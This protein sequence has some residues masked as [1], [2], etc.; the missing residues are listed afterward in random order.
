M[1]TKE[2]ALEKAKKM[3]YGWNTGKVELVPLKDVNKLIR[4]IYSIKP[5]TFK[6]LHKGMWVWID[7]LETIAL[8]I[9]FIQGYIIEIAYIEFDVFTRSYEPV[10]EIFH[11]ADNTLYPITKTM[12]YQ[13]MRSKT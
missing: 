4:E 5:Y 11:F 1:L 8:I 9:G 12:E 6:D 7:E 3:S 13:E 2:E 10:K